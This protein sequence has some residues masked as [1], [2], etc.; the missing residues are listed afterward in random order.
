MLNR[1]R[2]FGMAVSLSGL[3]IASCSCG[4]RKNNSPKNDDSIDKILSSDRLPKAVKDVAESIAGKNARKFA[5]MVSYPLTRP[6]PLRNIE[7]FEQMVDYFPVMVDDS[8]RHVITTGSVEDWSELGWRGWTVAGGEYL[9]IDEK[10]Y[11]VPY[12]SNAEKKERQRLITLDTLSLHQSL[13]GGWEPVDCLRSNNRGRTY[14]IDRNPKLRARDEYR[15]AIWEGDAPLSSEPS[16][17]LS[18]HRQ[19]EGSA[20]ITT[21][22]FTSSDGA[23]AIYSPDPTDISEPKRI[24]LSTPDNNTIV[25]DTVASVYWQDIRK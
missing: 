16:K 1:F 17:V 15:L 21:Y 6:Y 19:S 18:G 9:W 8:L 3:M 7:D 11:D 13:R 25:S 5:G 2:T 14:R 20:D 4:P 24:V 23:S 12:L 22:F 10:I